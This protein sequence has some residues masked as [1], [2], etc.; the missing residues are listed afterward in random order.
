MEMRLDRG[1]SM[2][3]L[4][5]SQQRAY[6]A[7]LKKRSGTMPTRSELPRSLT[8]LGLAHTT[9]VKGAKYE[10]PKSKTQTEVPQTDV[11]AE[12]AIAAAQRKEAAIVALANKN[13]RLKQLGQTAITASSLGAPETTSVPE[14]AAAPKEIKL[15]YTSDTSLR[16]DQQTPF[17]EDESYGY[18][19]SGRKS[20]L[21]SKVPSL[22]ALA[23]KAIAAAER[24]QEETIAGGLRAEKRR[25]AGADQINYQLDAPVK[26]IK[27]KTKAEDAQAIE[28]IRQTFET[29]RDNISVVNESPSSPIETYQPLDDRLI[30][31]RNASGE[32][33]AG[34][35][36]KLSDPDFEPIV[37]APRAESTDYAVSSEDLPP[38]IHAEALTAGLQSVEDAA[39]EGLADEFVMETA[40]DSPM[41]VDRRKRS[42][43]SLEDIELG[44][45]LE[46]H[47]E[48]TAAANAER[49]EA[50]KVA[51][52]AELN[53]RLAERD[54]ELA[55]EEA[56][57]NDQA[58]AS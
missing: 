34:R 27:F 24:K 51:A 46:A 19:D 58:A 26:P 40:V 7:G 37:D 55:A 45:V 30:A 1:P 39:K 28:N 13:N 57:E 54:A 43:A 33:A 17:E 48:K 53:K 3:G 36:R 49:R 21:T 41:V 20:E 10:A 25:L 42:K 47:H 5:E 6:V 50:K 23:K 14:V 31:D 44:K 52:M 11:M 12:R 18:Q 2:G 32:R 8:N 22:D 35:D 4:S 15:E 16:A 29:N 9:E 56:A 38:P